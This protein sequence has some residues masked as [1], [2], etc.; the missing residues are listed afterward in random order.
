MNLACMLHVQCTIRSFDLSVAIY[1]YINE[2]K[3]SAR[4]CR[5]CA[6][7]IPYSSKFLWHNIYEFHDLT[8]DKKIFLAKIIV[9][10]ATFCVHIRIT[11]AIVCTCTHAIPVNV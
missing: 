8:S 10:V 5:K 11:S 1:I 6:C 2:A 7:Y 9:G 3:L 4:L